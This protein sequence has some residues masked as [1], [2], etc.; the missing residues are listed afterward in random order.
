M[1]RIL[2]IDDEASVQ[3]A[4]RRLLQ[5]SGHDVTLAA[6]GEEGLAALETGAYD[7]ILSDMRMPNLDGPSFYRELAHRQPHLLP[8]V[9]FLTG[10]VL[11]AEADAFFAQAEC[12]RLIKPFKGQEVRRIIQ[13]VLE[14]Q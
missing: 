5:H 9:V 13:Q 10:D 1:P 12:P 8:R 11:S 2:V 4:L 6:S 7:V 3:R 14:A